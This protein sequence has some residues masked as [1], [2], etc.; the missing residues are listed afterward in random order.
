[1]GVT[2]SRSTHYSDRS[3][4]FSVTIPKCLTDVYVNS[5]FPCT[6]RL[7]NS[8]HIACFPLNYDLYSLSLESTDTFNCRF[9]LNRFPV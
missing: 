1:M 3:H 6:A 8:L 2:F 9:F 5:F 4:K 7:W